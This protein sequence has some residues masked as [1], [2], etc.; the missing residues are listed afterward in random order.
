[1]SDE[2]MTPTILARFQVQKP[3]ERVDTNRNIVNSVDSYNMSLNR[4]Q[5]AALTAIGL[6]LFAIFMGGLVRASGA[7]L[8]CPDWPKCFGSWIPPASAA[9]LPPGFDPSQFN[10]MK[11]WTEYTNRLAGILTVFSIIVTAVLSFWYRKD[12]PAVFYS[13]IAALGMVLFQGWLGGVVVKSGLTEWLIT[14]HLW[15]AIAIVFMLLYA[16]FK[17]TEERWSLQFRDN[18]VSRRIYGIGLALLVLTVIQMILG[19]QVRA[20]VDTV[21]QTMAGLPKELWI[22][23]AGTIVAIHRSFSWIIFLLG[24]ALCY[25]AWQ[26]TDSGLLRKIAAGVMASVVAQMLLGAGLYYIALPPSVE[27]L[28]V[29]GSAI[30]ISFEF[31]LILAADFSIRKAPFGEYNVNPETTI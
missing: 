1:M 9:A 26:K 22:A 20:S 18:K 7:G 14:A 12:R 27:V 2:L 24:I 3:D 10:L 8:G 13:S 25:L 29:L 16:I 30:L 6:T 4:Y 21:M 5:K 11:M 23:Q 31:L 19:T 28:H 17:A 15:L